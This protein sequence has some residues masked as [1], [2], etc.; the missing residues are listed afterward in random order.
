MLLNGNT[1]ML[2]GSKLTNKLSD[3]KYRKNNL[4]E[5]NN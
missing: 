1:R 3:K 5:I 2:E 4:L